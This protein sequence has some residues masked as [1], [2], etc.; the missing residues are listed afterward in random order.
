MREM[1]FNR[2]SILKPAPE[3]SPYHVRAEGTVGLHLI[4]VAAALSVGRSATAEEGITTFI[5]SPT[6]VIGRAAL[7][8]ATGGIGGHPPVDRRREKAQSER[9]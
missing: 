6:L 1:E 3:C 4:K 8:C 9:D 7:A 5:Q 2:L